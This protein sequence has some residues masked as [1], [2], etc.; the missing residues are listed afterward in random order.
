MA[1]KI[2]VVN[3]LIPFLIFA[4]NSH[5]GHFLDRAINHDNTEFRFLASL[6]EME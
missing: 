1:I 5:T 6:T 3:L 4:G 2:K